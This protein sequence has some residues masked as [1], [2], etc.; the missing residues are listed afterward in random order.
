MPAM[1]AMPAT[2]PMPS[3]R[4]PRIL[5]VVQRF[6]PEMG[7][8]ETHVA[9]VAT[10]LAARGEFDVTVLATDRTGR[11]ARHDSMDGYQVLRRRSWPEKR[12]FYVSPGL[13]AEIVRGSWDLVHVQGIHTAVPP[14]AMAAARA[15]R[16]PYVLTFHSGGH[17]SPVRLGMRGL[18]WKALTPLLRSADHLIAVSRFERSHFSAATGIDPSGFTVVPNGGALPA[19]PAQVTPRPGRIV[20][21]GRLE[22]YKGHHRAIEALPLIRSRIPSA[23]LLILGSG[24]YEAE[25]RALAARLGVA[26]AVEI[27]HLPPSDRAAMAHELGTASVM[28]A[29]SSYEAHPVGIMEAVTLGL[30]V[31]GLDVAGTGD[32]VEDQLVTGIPEDA[33]TEV[34][35]AALTSALEATYARGGPH[36]PQPLDLPTWET[37]ADGVSK[38]YRDVLARRGRLPRVERV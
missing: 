4:R 22:L 2:P 35:A 17:S 19:A 5:T 37:T 34:V 15:S 21:S 24:T 11:L 20:S 28:A 10:R 7:G 13:V 36:R 32:L 25:L 38:V 23:D 14:M 26:D 3:S 18:Q 31:V 1:P 30:P 9:E 12:D 8:T 33:S 29:L 16:T 27:R 6:F